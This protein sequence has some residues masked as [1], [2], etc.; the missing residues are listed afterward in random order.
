MI[1]GTGTTVYEQVISVN[2]DNQP[3]TAT[4][5]DIQMY[6]DGMLESGVIFNTYL[7]DSE[8]AVFNISWSASTT[9]TYQ[10]YAKNNE[11]SVIF[12]S[13]NVVVKPDSELGTNVYI[14]L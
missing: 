9:G 10:M 12:I 1:I 4:T 5:F 14:G 3:V 13:N 2:D 7:L 6:R 8:R 11:T